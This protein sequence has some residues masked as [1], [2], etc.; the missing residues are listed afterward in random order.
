MIQQIP[1]S[2]PWLALDLGS[3]FT[4]LYASNQNI[5]VERCASRESAI[6]ELINTHSIALKSAPQVFLASVH[7]QDLTHKLEKLLKTKTTQLIRIR[8]RQLDFLQSRYAIEQLGVDR[9]LQMLGLQQ[10]ETSHERLSAIFSFGTAITLDVLH[11]GGRK[12]SSLHEGGKILPNRHGLAESLRLSTE[13][14]VAEID[15]ELKPHLDYAHTTQAA[16]K[17]GIDSLIALWLEQEILALAARAKQQSL[18]L[19]LYFTGGEAAIWQGYFRAKNPQA[20]VPILD[21]M[22]LY[23]GIAI[24]SSLFT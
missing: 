10:A 7:N 5:L 6:Q 22:L 3:S 8:P 19:K 1:S 17:S 20:F 12:T 11:L 16:I 18:G 13:L 23:K 15:A 2:K 21:N 9:W 24:Y 14:E 4:K